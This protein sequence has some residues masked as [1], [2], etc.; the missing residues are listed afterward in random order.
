MQAQAEATRI[1]EREIH[2]LVE[3]YGKET[4]VTA[5][6]EVQDY[7]ETLTRQ[8]VSKL[9]NG[10]WETE[11][12]IDVDPALGEGLIPIRVKMTIEGD[13]DPLRP[14]GVASEVAFDVPQR[15]LRRRVR[16]DRR[17][18]EDPVPG[19]PAQLRLLPR[20]HPRPWPERDSRQR[21]VADALCRLLL[22]AL[23][24]DHE[25]DLRALGGPDAR[26]GDGVHVQPRVSAR[27]RPRRSLRGAPV[28]HV[29]RLDGRRL[30]RA[31]RP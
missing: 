4:I 14:I 5:F 7:V 19:H 18:H 21:G 24:E 15:L 23:R 22:R 28:L 29:V 6:S 12:Y 31:Q 2:R 11:D 26:A 13:S 1:A 9:P 27:R 16:R 20:R 17:R 10:T 8:R 25:L 30:G 3:K